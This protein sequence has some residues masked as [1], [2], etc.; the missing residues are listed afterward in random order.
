MCQLTT[1]VVYNYKKPVT[2]AIGKAI[3]NNL[4]FFRRHCGKKEYVLISSVETELFPKSRS[5]H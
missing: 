4:I 2:V 1:G 5:I 3:F